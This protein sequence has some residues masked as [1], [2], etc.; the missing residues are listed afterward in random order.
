MFWIT[1]GVLIALQNAMF[2][3][4]SRA[5]NSDSLLSHAIAIPIAQLVYFGC[6]L[7]ALDNGLKVIKQHDWVAGTFQVAL[8]VCCTSIG[9]LSTHWISLKAKRAKENA[10]NLK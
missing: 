1:W 4:T 10:K 8:Y 2:T 9:S 7:F 6:S 3:W 5:R